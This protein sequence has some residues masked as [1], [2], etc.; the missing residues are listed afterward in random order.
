M[1][2]F[3]FHEKKYT[4]PFSEVL[5]VQATGPENFF[6]HESLVKFSPDLETLTD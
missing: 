1:R 3:S 2:L 5:H 6:S 4:R